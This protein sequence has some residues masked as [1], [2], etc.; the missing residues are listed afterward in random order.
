MPGS[1]RRTAPRGDSC[2]WRPDQSIESPSQVRGTSTRSRSPSSKRFDAWAKWTPD[3]APVQFALRDVSRR[4]GMLCEQ[5]RETGFVGCG[6]GHVVG[7]A[8]AGA[9]RRGGESGGIGEAPHGLGV[10]G[11]LLVE[12]IRPAVFLVPV[13]LA[14]ERADQS[15]ILRPPVVARGPDRLRRRRGVRKACLSD[16]LRRANPAQPRRAR[17]PSATSSIAPLV[18]LAVNRPADEDLI[19][20]GHCFLPS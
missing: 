6:K 13:P 19:V 20:S 1:W 8:T 11:H 9:E 10:H 12:R 15:R 7:G 3:S 14:D 5:E 2:G 17:F 16:R 4:S 18:C